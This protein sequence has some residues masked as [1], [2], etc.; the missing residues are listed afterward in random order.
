MRPPPVHLPVV[1]SS[2]PP[3]KLGLVGAGFML[4]CSPQAATRSPAARRPPHAVGILRFDMTIPPASVTCVL[5]VSVGGR[6]GNRRAKRLGRGGADGA[7]VVSDRCGVAASH[8][9]H[10]PGAMWRR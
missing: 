2:V 3:Q 8:S 4:V 7:E 10:V 9:T 5:L 6:K 1:H